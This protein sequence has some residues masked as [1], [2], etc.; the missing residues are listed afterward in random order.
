M[1]VTGSSTPDVFCRNKPRFND[2]VLKS[3]K[4]L[5]IEMGEI[6]KEMGNQM[7]ETFFRLQV[8]L[9]AN[10]TIT[11]NNFSPTIQ[12]VFFLALGKMGQL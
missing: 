1:Q 8:F 2:Q 11:A 3:A 9:A 7:P 4:E 5:S 6:I 10:M 12:T